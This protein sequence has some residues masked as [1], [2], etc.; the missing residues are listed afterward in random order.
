LGFDTFGLQNGYQCFCGDSL[1]LVG[2][3]T[4]KDETKCDAKCSGNKEQERIL[5]LNKSIKTKIETIC[6]GHLYN[7]IYEIN[8]QYNK[9]FYLMNDEHLLRDNN[10]TKHFMFNKQ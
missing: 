6:G 5:L 3:T 1:S 4:I 9:K 7:S 2:R 8:L 10:L